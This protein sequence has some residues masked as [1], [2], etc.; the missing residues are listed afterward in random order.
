MDADKYSLAVVAFLGS[1]CE[2]EIT[3]ETKANRRC[4]LQCLHRNQSQTKRFCYGQ[5]NYDREE[6]FC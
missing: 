3:A 2:L 6:S 4:E 5:N 1:R